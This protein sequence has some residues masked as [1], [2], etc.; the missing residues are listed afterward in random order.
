MIPSKVAKNCT[1]RLALGL[2]F[3]TT[4]CGT[5][6]NRTDTVKEKNLDHFTVSKQV[7]NCISDML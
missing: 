2:F 7:L 3:V 5:V 1:L 6:L 4:G